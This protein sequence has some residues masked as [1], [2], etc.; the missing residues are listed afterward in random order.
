[1]VEGRTNWNQT[2]TVLAANIT[3]REVDR[4]TSRKETQLVNAISPY[5]TYEFRVSA[6]NQLGYGP[7]SLASPQY[8]TRPDRIYQPP[9][10]V[11]GGG[12]KTGD[13][14]I[15]WSPFKGQQQNASGIYYKVFWRRLVGADPSEVSEESEFQSQVVKNSRAAG[16]LVVTIDRNRRYFYTKYNVKGNSLVSFLIYY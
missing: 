6:A 8:N 14:T 11:G 13:L 2:W 12:G 4:L 3:A 15:T 16:N 1:M 10:N 7:P 5:S 9:A